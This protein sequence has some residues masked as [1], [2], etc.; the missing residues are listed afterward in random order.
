MILAHP[1]S[2]ALTFGQA[3][4]Q[5]TRSPLEVVASPLAEN[6]AKTS[7]SFVNIVSKALN[8][9]AEPPFLR[10]RREAEAADKDYRTAV[11]RLDRQR[12]GLE[13]RIEDMLKALQKWE[14]ERLRAVKTGKTFVFLLNSLSNSGFGQFC[15]NIKDPSLVCAKHTIPPWTVRLLWFRH[16]TLTRI[17]MP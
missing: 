15:S 2:Q 4:S 6:L 3:P 10:L 9:S 12:L 8:S 5:P 14:T 17:S 16:T 13:E 7:T 11:R 1:T